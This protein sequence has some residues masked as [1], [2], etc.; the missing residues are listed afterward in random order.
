MGEEKPW[1]KYELPKTVMIKGA[2]RFPSFFSLQ[3]FRT[4]GEKWSSSRGANFR[5]SRSA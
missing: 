3:G 5:L 1:K 2:V 4:I